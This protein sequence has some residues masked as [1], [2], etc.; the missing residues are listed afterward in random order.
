MA[1]PPTPEIPVG[2]DDPRQRYVNYCNNIYG[3]A[4]V[5]NCR[6]P[7]DNPDPAQ[8]ASEITFSGGISAATQ[9]ACLNIA[10]NTPEAFGGWSPIPIPDTDG[11]IH[12]L[13]TDPTI[14]Q[15]PVALIMGFA[16]A[17]ADMSLTDRQNFNSVA[18]IWVNNAYPTQGPTLLS[19]ISGYATYRWVS[20]TAAKPAVQVDRPNPPPPPPPKPEP[21]RDFPTW[22]LAALQKQKPSTIM[23]VDLL[24]QLVTQYQQQAK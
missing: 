4:T 19:L 5:L 6:V 24:K 2:S 18:S 13:V 17:N 12:D 14:S 11:F 7:L 1:A 3:N 22:L 8:M 9:Q 20:L 15:F 16:L 21:V 23:T 10:E